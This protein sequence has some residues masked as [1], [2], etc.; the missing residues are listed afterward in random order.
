MLRHTL[1]ELAHG[2]SLILI[3]GTIVLLCVALSGCSDAQMARHRAVQACMAANPP[4][5]AHQVA[6]AFGLIGG[7]VNA[8]SDGDRNAA[9]DQC[10]ADLPR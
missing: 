10:V 4:S 3:L 9:I 5:A 1:R 2:F 6:G 7:L 8:A